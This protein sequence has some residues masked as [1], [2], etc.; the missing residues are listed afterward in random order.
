MTPKQQRIAIAEACGWKDVEFG[1]GPNSN[2]CL[3]DKPSWAHGKVQSYLVDQR[4]PDYLNDLNAMHEAEKRITD[5]PKW[6]KM[7][8]KIIA[9]VPE[10]TRAGGTK[11]FVD[12]S[13]LIRATA[14][15]RAEAF[16]RTLNLWK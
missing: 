3:G 16:L 2:L 9:G 7:L 14:A 8:A 11:V 12:N 13:I 1:V 10:A 6:V 5:W 4:V 15:Q